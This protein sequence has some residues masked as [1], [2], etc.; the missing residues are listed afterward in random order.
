MVAVSTLVHNVL[1]RTGV[2]A[3]I[4]ANHR[5]GL[6]CYGASGCEAVLRAVVA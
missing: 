2:L 1:A 3:A 6:A 5:Y 4:E